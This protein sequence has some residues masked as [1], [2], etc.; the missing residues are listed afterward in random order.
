MAQGPEA[1]DVGTLGG[2]EL[3]PGVQGGEA[4]LPPQPLRNRRRGGLIRAVGELDGAA[5]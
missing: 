1:P 2:G 4:D 5:A 3:T